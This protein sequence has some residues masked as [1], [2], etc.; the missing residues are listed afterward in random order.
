MDELKLSTAN[1]G[2]PSAEEITDKERIKKKRGCGCFLM[3]CFALIL[4]LSLPPIGFLVYLG[5]LSDSDYG[6][7][8]VQILE[9]PDVAQ[10]VKEAL[11]DNNDLSSDEKAALTAAYDALLN[12]YDTL[13]ADKKDA[14]NRNI[15]AVVRKA[16]TDPD[17]FAK[18]PPQELSD[19]LNTLGIG[20][21][22]R[23]PPPVTPP[24]PIVAPTVPAEPK[25]PQ[26]PYS[27]DL[28]TTPDPQAK[29]DV[30]SSQYDF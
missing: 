27:F 2:Y 10:A 24:N 19:L 20:M 22:T 18:E 16:L 23:V 8:A 25:K 29:D 11:R 13:P 15:V 28:P 7:F 6:A 26:D 5:T 12:K 14:V 3:G 21:P 1:P 30:E 4:L 9:N 17:A